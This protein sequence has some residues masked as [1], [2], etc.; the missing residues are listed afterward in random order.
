MLHHQQP[1]TQSS[2]EASTLDLCNCAVALHHL[3]ALH[4]VY[5]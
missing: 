4:V 2:T 1:G 5:A 3:R